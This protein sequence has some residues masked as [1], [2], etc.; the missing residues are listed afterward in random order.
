MKVAWLQK[1]KGIDFAE[2]RRWLG[3]NYGNR[4]Q[5]RRHVLDAIN[6][7]EWAMNNGELDQVGFG[8]EPTFQTTAP[9]V[10]PHEFDRW[11]VLAVRS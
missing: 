3:D 9:Y 7:L 11:L 5:A 10:H 8:T 2:A 1:A 4:D 6:C